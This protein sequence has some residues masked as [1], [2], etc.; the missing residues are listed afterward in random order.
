MSLQ[1][2]VQYNQLLFPQQLNAIITSAGK[3]LDNFLNTYKSTELN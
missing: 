2:N 1:I 3:D